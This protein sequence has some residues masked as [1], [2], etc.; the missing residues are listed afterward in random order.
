MLLLSKHASI[1]GDWKNSS[2]SLDSDDNLTKR[3]DPSSLTT[4]KAFDLS[5]LLAAI[6]SS[7]TLRKALG[8]GNV[9]SKLESSLRWKRQKTSSSSDFMNTYCDCPMVVKVTA[10]VSALNWLSFSFHESEPMYR[11]P[12]LLRRISVTPPSVSTHVPP[13]RPFLWK[14]SVRRSVC[15]WRLCRNPQATT[16]PLL[17]TRLCSSL[18]P[19][20]FK[21]RLSKYATHSLI[22]H[23]D[24]FD[25]R[26]QPL[27][28]SDRFGRNAL[29][30]V[31]YTVECQPLFPQTDVTQRV[32][33]KA[34]IF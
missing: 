11:S 17:R 23:R 19:H 32:G 6:D 7:T 13:A 28:I 8:S 14:K 26:V 3:L 12:F 9:S 1:L 2:S 20:S 10:R 24:F 16:T 5:P 25:A 31:T 30:A 15:R 21:V 27:A 33:S 22:Q 4:P 18:S 29:S 34:C